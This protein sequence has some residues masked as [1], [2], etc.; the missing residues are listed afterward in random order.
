VISTVIVCSVVA[1]VAVGTHRSI[2]WWGWCLAAIVPVVVGLS[3]IYL[4][5][6]WLTDVIA[7][8]VIGGLWVALTIRFLLRPDAT[9]GAPARG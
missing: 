3:R 8:W 6:H 2:R 9:R 7:G 1:A 4:G 5:V